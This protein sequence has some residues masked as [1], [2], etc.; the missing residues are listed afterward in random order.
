MARIV[1]LE[2]AMVPTLEREILPRLNPHMPAERWRRLFLPP[3]RHEGGLG[4]V[5]LDG[6]RIVGLLGTLFG[7][8]EIG[9]TPHRVC[10]LHSWYVAPEHRAMSLM[11]LKPLLAMRDVTL[12]DFSPSP[13][14][15][16]ISRRL[17]FQILDDRMHV[18]PSLPLPRRTAAVVH[19][20]DTEAQAARVLSPAD[21]AL[22]RDHQALDCEHLVAKAGDE[23]CYVVHT[24]HRQ[25]LLRYRRVQYLSHPAL[26]ARHHHAIRQ[27]AL[28]RDGHALVVG[29][30]R[31]EGH[32]VPWSVQARAHPS[33]YR[34]SAPVTALDGLYSEL[35]VLGLPLDFTALR[36]LA[37]MRQ[38]LR[39]RT[40]AP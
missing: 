14:V 37:S 28:R 32:R 38:R 36:A 12:T 30:R 18:L 27:H 6:E 34:G 11:L 21:L 33:L 39:G 7:H 29:V 15:L 9:G 22:Y 3:W 40:H 10:N 17:G 25:R 23:Y 4:Q 24:G 20:L 16:E 2:A 35:P 26:F 1:P 31:L 13:R 8:R 5:L 19:T